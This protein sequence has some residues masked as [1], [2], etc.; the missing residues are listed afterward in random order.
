VEGVTGK[1]EKA[2]EA[3]RVNGTERG[4][5]EKKTKLGKSVEKKKKKREGANKITVGEK[6]F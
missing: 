2:G 5:L 1:L 6:K 4:M 3:A